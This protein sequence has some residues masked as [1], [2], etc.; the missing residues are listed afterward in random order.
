MSFA[1][2]HGTAAGLG[3]G[4]WHG[5]SAVLYVLACLCVVVMIHKDEYRHA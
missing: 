5:I 2:V 4:A 3:F 1:Q